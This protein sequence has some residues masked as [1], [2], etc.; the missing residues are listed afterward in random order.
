MRTLRF[1]S[2]PV[3]NLHS[4]GCRE[5][6]KSNIWSGGLWY[7]WRDYAFSAPPA[8]LSSLGPSAPSTGPCAHRLLRAL[9][10]RHCLDTLT[11][12]AHPTPKTRR[13]VITPR[14]YN[15]PLTPRATYTACA[16]ASDEVRL[17]SGEGDGGGGLG[18]NGGC[19]GLPL[20]GDDGGSKGD[21]GGGEGEGGG[22]LGDGGGGLGD[23]G[24]GVGGGGEGDG[25]GGDGGG[26][27][28][29]GGGGEG[30]GGGGEG[31]GG[32]GGEGE[33]GGCGDEGGSGGG[34]EGGGGGAGTGGGGGGGEYC[35]TQYD[36][37]LGHAPV[38]AGLQMPAFMHTP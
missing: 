20:G 10:F 17:R 16:S 6:K 2:Y 22:G 28:G 36:I 25:G 1:K 3:T 13:G 19:S 38:P 34:S 8:D 15:T 30:C 4:G 31:G 23:G 9:H 11:L 33:G 32:L 24:G 5:C 35:W 18:G 21:G 29:G 7:R 37:S 14:R 27:E 12:T 26:G